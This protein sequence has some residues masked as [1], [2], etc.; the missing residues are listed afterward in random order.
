MKARMSIAAAVLLASS[1]AFA[2]CVP[3]KYREG[4]VPLE[5]KLDCK[6]TISQL[7]SRSLL[8]Q[9]KPIHGDFAQGDSLPLLR[10]TRPGGVCITQAESAGKFYNAEIKGRFGCQGKI[11]PIY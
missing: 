7:C 6:P 5:K 8:R 11:V 3:V 10:H 4:C 2:E 9:E 1:A